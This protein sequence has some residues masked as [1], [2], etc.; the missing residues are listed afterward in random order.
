MCT[1]ISPFTIIH[2]LIYSLDIKTFWNDQTWSLTYSWI[3]AHLFLLQDNIDNLYSPKI[4]I[5]LEIQL[6]LMLQ[7]IM[8]FYPGLVEGSFNMRMISGT[9]T[10][11]LRNGFPQFRKENFTVLHLWDELECWLWAGPDHPAPAMDK[12][13]RKIKKSKSINSCLML[14]IK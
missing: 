14:Y 10:D 6:M 2:T 8:L 7:H 9:K 1:K 5:W 11:P 3:V 4:Y 12:T 13:G